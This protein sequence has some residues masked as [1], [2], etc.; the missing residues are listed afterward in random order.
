[1]IAGLLFSDRH[2]GPIVSITGGAAVLAA[3]LVGAVTRD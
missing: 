1:M 2:Y 3:A